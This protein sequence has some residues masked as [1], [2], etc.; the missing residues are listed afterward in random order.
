MSEVQRSN[1]AITL[2]VACLGSFMLLLDTS[3]VTLALPRIQ[4]DLHANL[5]DLQWTVDAY[6]LPFAV[7][8]L[9]AG[10]LGDR[11]G[12]KRLFLT[13]LILFVIG[14]ALSGFAP[15]LSWLLFGRVVQGVGA[16]ALSPG[17]LSVLVAAFSDARAR[18][19]AIGAWSGIS[20]IALA[21]GPLLG[22]V[23]VHVWNWPAI[24]FIN[25]PIGLIA[26]ALGWSGLTESRNPHAR[27]LDLPGQVLV[28]AGLTCLVMGIIEAGSLGWTSPVILSL[29]AGAVIFLIAFVLVEQRTREPLLPLQLFRIRAFS[30]SNIVAFIVGVTILSTIFFIAQYFQQVQGYSVLEAGLRTFPISMGAFLMAPFAGM[31]AGRIGSRVPMLVGALLTACAVLLLTVTIRPD[32]SY[33]SL[34]WILALMGLGLGLTL[35]PATAAVSSATPPNRVAL[36]SSMFTTSNEIGNTIGV[37]VIGALVVLQFSGNIIAQLTQRGISSQVSTSIA[38]QVAL[39][40]AQASHLSLPARLPMS[41]VA[42]HQALNQAFVDSL[43]GSFLISSALLLL[44]AL[45]VA[46]AFRQPPV[47]EQEGQ[48]DVPVVRED[49][50]A[51]AA[52]ER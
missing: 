8:M 47:S 42:L 13:G 44:A 19:Q 41:S 7:L 34:W 38:Q 48:A 18:T 22:G 30:V 39:A 15:T 27:H 29:F 50:V 9:S 6:I 46:V 35:S 14:S 52:E 32:S 2:I 49:Y 43:R 4:A 10:T 5:S 3:I 20:G 25:V 31:I 28:I 21:I 37:A 17:S 36:G 1:K 12:R 51:T 16:A 45:L 24:F 11:F 40:G 23:L 33:G 26:L